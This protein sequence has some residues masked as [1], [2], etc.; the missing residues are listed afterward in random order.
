MKRVIVIVM[1]SVGIGELPD[2]SDY[3]DKGSN[4]LGNIAAA[5][6]NFNLPNMKALGLGNIDG[7]K[8]LGYCVNASGC[9]GRMMEKSAGKDSTTGHW[10]IAGIILDKPFPVYPDGFP[11][12]II[13]KFEKE[14]GKGVLGNCTASG[15]EIIKKL[16]K[17]HM[18]TGKP[19][20]YTSQ[21]SVFQIA[22]H[23]DII[24]VNELYKIC[25]TARR[26][27]QGEYAVGR[28][29]ARPF[30]GEPGSFKRTSRRKDFSLNPVSMTMLDYMT[31]NS[32]M[33]KAVGKIK[34][35]F[36]GRGIKEAVHTDNNMEGVDRTLEYLKQEFE[37]LIFTNCVDFDML[38]GHRNDVGGYAEALMEFD[39]RLPEIINC[40]KENDIL[41]ITADHGCD[42]TTESTDHSREYVPLLITGD[43]L[44]KGVNLGT[45]YAF[46]D[47]AATV[48]KYFNIDN[49]LC[50]VSFLDEIML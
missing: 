20:V 41:I 29:I 13:N 47:I 14:T 18:N 19:I 27:M 45:R 44:K 40:L 15:T 10:E 38:Y 9:F 6:K 11:K 1:D 26:I 8:R 23:E 50:G 42:P 12:E 2:A 24:D 25:S 32:Y 34:D 35:I 3:G 21:D 5:V 33:V 30:I 17:L 46:A 22:A 48:M 4:T 28:V 31:K 16:G 43:K 37:G 49:D 36:N 7:T 39:K